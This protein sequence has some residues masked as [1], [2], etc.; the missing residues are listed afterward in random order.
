MDA[1]E[2][3]A[4]QELQAKIL[5]WCS[6]TARS[7]RPQGVAEHPVMREGGPDLSRLCRVLDTGEGDKLLAGGAT[8]ESV[9]VQLLT[10]SVNALLAPGH[11][12]RMDTGIFVV[13]AAAKYPGTG[14]RSP[15]VMTVTRNDDKKLTKY[16]GGCDELAGVIVRDFGTVYVERALAE[17]LGAR[18]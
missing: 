10:R 17:L 6:N 13:V 3:R 9:W 5:K 16:E 18:P 14:S 7:T 8:W 1:N 11:V 12:F 2:L 15:G 4:S